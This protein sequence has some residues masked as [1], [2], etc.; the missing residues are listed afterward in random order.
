MLA[1]LA[2][3]WP[4]LKSSALQADPHAKEFRHTDFDR[5]VRRPLYDFAKTNIAW[6]VVCSPQNIFKQWVKWEHNSVSLSDEYARIRPAWNKSLA[7]ALP[8]P[9][10]SKMV[11]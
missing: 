6:R 5:L 8:S 2:E 7:Q 9:G 1:V 10:S 11:A 4:E 3:A